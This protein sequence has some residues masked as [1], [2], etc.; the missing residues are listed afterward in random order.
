MFDAPPPSLLERMKQL[1]AEWEGDKVADVLVEAARR[2]K[3]AEDL[4]LSF[5]PGGSEYFRRDGDGF[6][7]DIEA[8]GAV[9]KEQRMSGIKAKMEAARL[10]KEAN[11]ST[12]AREAE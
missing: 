11:C 7:V 1:A 4:L 9:I 10:R 3:A 6:R 12:P 8:C 5:T 2:L